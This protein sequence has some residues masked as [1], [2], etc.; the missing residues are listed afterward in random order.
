MLQVQ[1]ISFSYT[2]KQILKN[3]SFN[4]AVGDYLS[5]IGESGS[6]KSTLLKLLYGEYNLDDG[7]IFWKDKKIL[8]PEYNLVIGYDFI[9]YVA[10]EF[11]L[12]PFIS[13]E[14]NIGKF[15]SN[16]FP[17]EKKERITELLEVVELTNFAKTKVKLLSGGQKQRVALARAIAKQPEIILLDEPFSH[18]DNFK[19][20]SLRRRLFKYL[21]EKNIAC[22]VATHD[23]ED[24]LGYA[25]TMLV[26]DNTKVLAIDT[27]EILYK[28]PKTPLVASFFGEYNIIRGE[29]IY[30]H[31]LQL[32]EKSNLKV[33][34]KQSYFKG[35]Y[36][37][38]EAEFE[39]KTIFF[40]HL[41]EL[42]KGQ[43]LFL[44]K[45]K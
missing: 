41:K 31:Q 25:D 4:L 29:I 44:E 14:E 28:N 33:I 6:G 5:I 34:V 40:F 15:L 43:T 13:V 16:F 37:L 3:I 1:D 8:G 10:Q 30:A 26:L 18:I 35:N 2:N 22:I 23:K 9:K 45:I 12:M 36:C 27:P 42:Q 20:Q 24:V 19:K 38:I 17:K 21:K 7:S 39:S 11:D 32:T